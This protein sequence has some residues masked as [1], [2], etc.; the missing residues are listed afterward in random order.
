M[1]PLVLLCATKLMSLCAAVALVVSNSV[2]PY[3]PQPTRLLCP[4]D[5]PA[6]I[7]EWIA[8]PSSRASS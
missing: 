8:M 2:Q 5:F 4:W 1:S 6:R 3:G 7:L